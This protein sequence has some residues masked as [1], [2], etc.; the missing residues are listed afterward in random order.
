MKRAVLFI[1]A[2]LMIWQLVGCG[3]SRTPDAPTQPSTPA[4]G[5]VVK[6]EVSENSTGARLW[7]QFQ[8]EITKNPNATPKEIADVLVGT[9]VGQFDGEAAEVEKDAEFLAG[10]DNYRVTG[11]RSAAMYG[12]VI[13]SIAFIGYVFE[14]E[15]GTDPA[16]FV[17]SLTDNCNPRWNICVTAEQTACGAVGNRVFFLMCP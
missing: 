14:L 1:L 12:P 15:D 4:A 9:M 17:K 16:T 11:Y 2:V 10:F 5:N 3:C 13:G 7:A 6:P 8:Q